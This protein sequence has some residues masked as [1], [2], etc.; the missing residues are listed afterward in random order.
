M[1]PPPTGRAPARAR[2]C[3]AR[4]ALLDTAPLVAGYLPFGLVLGATI[5]ASPVPNLAGW[6]SSPLMF[7]GAA[8]L[9][10]VDLLSAGVPAVVIIAT[11]LVVNLRHVMYSGAMAPHFRATPLLWRVAAPHVLADPVYTLSA[12]RFSQMEHVRERHCYY[13]VLGCTLLLAWSAMTGAGVLIGAYLPATPALGL[14]VPLVFLALLAPTVTD[15]PSALAALVAA[16]VTVGAGG[17]PLRLALVVGP[18]SGMAA[19]ML[20]DRER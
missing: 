20:A 11:A 5:A 14:A 13:A 9:A 15:R 17:L 10:V 6:A 19:G 18:L 16:V 8:Q 7:S 2:R 1:H 12:V 4:Q 3:P